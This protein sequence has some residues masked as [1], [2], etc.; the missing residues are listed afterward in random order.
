MANLEKKEIL[1]KVS[2]KVSDKDL[3]MEL[4]EDITDSFEKTDETVSKKDYDNVKVE[5]DLM[6]K[7]Y[8]DL[9]DKYISRF[10]DVQSTKENT[11][12]KEE[13]IEN[14]IVDVRSIF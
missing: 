9:Q 14:K 4:L 11:I 6:T 7:K 2:E 10:S 1:D 3:Q 8:N 13:P 12:V 5:L